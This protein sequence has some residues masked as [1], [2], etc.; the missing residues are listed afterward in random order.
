[1][2]VLALTKKHLDNSK[3]VPLNMRTRTTITGLLLVAVTAALWNIQQ[4]LLAFAAEDEDNNLL[5]VRKESITTDIFELVSGIFA[6][7][8]CVLSLRAY[9]KLKIKA[10]L[11]V[12]AA[13]GIFAARTIAIE[14]RDLYVGGGES[15]ALETILSFMFL[16]ALVL[17][18]IAIVQR[19]R[20]KPKPPQPDI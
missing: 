4:S 10:M 18:F 15:P 8:L 11:F 5:H 17:F 19:E 20:I 12:S 7:I 16:M 6:A 2:G 14:T 9:T 1:M 3:G 13:F